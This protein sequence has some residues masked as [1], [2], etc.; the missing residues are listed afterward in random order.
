MGK[1]GGTILQHTHDLWEVDLQEFY[2]THNLTSNT[3]RNIA[4]QSCRIFFNP[5]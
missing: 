2:F 3:V 1:G 5:R 4:V